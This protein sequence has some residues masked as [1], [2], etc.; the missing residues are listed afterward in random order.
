MIT[1]MTM[2]DG[3]SSLPSLELGRFTVVP[4]TPD[5]DGGV[6][7]VRVDDLSVLHVT[8]LVF[9]AGQWM[10]QAETEVCV[11]AGPCVHQQNQN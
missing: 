7:D 3:A 5:G 9:E 10:S 11:C 6:V 1:M 4:G 8:G 2:M